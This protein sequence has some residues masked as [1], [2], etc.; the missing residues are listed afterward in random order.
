M[1]FQEKIT[2][3]KVNLPI[4]ENEISD[5]FPSGKYIDRFS[6]D[7]LGSYR[8]I[9]EK[10]KMKKKNFPKV[11]RINIEDVN[12]IAASLD[13]IK[14]E[15]DRFAAEVYDKISDIEKLLES[16]IILMIKG[17]SFY[18]IMIPA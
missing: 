2:I 16:G 9:I 18:L 17:L 6:K 13:N 3:K 11:D 8:V 12:E 4:I 7:D 10:K 5:E 14:I 1:K 15:I